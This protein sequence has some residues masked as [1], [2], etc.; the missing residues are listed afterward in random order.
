MALDARWESGKLT[1]WWTRRERKIDNA[2]SVEEQ[3]IVNLR[4]REFF[5]RNIFGAINFE[6]LKVIMETIYSSRRIYEETAVQMHCEKDIWRN[7]GKNLLI[8]KIFWY[9]FCKKSLNFDTRTS[10]SRNSTRLPGK[11]PK[12]CIKFPRHDEK[13]RNKDKQD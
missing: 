3:W 12:E 1:W 5:D 7:R 2:W 11:K 4:L 9:F 8:R 6:W 10:V 13:R